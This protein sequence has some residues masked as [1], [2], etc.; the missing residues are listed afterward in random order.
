MPQPVHAV[1]GR[2]IALRLE[3]VQLVV[4]AHLDRN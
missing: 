1:D 4:I 3:T 2:L